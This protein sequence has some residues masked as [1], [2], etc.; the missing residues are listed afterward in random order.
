MLT[1]SIKRLEE[2]EA[3]RQETMNSSLFQEW[4][5]DLRVSLCYSDPEPIYKAREMNEQ[6]SFN[7]NK[8]AGM[9]KVSY[10]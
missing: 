1:T 10:L 3:E 2:I 6:Y 7:R 9:G 8:V 4:V 5:N